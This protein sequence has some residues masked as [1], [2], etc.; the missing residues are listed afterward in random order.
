MFKLFVFVTL[1]TLALS[2]DLP[3]PHDFINAIHDLEA[4]RF[5]EYTDSDKGNF[6][7]GGSTASVGQFPYQ[8]SLRSSAN[9]HF[10]GGILAN[11]RWVV[12][13]AHCTVGRTL[14][15]TR[16]I[17]GAHSRTTGGTNF[18][19]GRIVNHPSYNSNT[20]ANDVSVLQTSANIGFTNVIQPIALGS[21]NV[22]GGVTAVLSGWGLTSSP[23]SLAANLQFLH[24]Q[25]MTNA[26]CQGRV[27]G[28][29]NLIF[30]HKI[31]AGGVTGQ[32]ACSGDSGGPLAAGGSAI[33]IVSW[34][35]PCARGFAD[36][37]DRVSSHRNWII[38]HF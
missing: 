29:G 35:I 7:V 19:T 34:G 38:G 31:C 16:I 33:G 26:N 36:V 27:G 20:I 18:A 25:T 10:C 6:V 32:G 15:N 14:A 5:V 4:G 12:S 30:A 28:N 24:K 2:E 3:T 1:A 23:G 11:N 37:Y 17:L 13:A 9:A 21:A 22:G 8:A